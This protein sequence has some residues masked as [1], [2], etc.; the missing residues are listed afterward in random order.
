MAL[1]SV[2]MSGFANQLQLQSIPHAV[3]PVLWP[4]RTWTCQ[5]EIDLYLYSLSF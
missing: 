3:D 1:I 5:G 4:G 2:V